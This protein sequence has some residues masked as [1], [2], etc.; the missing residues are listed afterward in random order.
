MADIAE[1]QEVDALAAL[2]DGLAHP[3]RVCILHVLRKEKRMLGTELRKRVSE[4]YV[5]IDARNLQFHLFKMQTAGLVSV[6]KEANR[7]MVEL[8]R[9]VV[10]RTKAA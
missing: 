6:R 3:L 9:D 1:P 8:V 4:M 10:L 2:H 7:D 5:P